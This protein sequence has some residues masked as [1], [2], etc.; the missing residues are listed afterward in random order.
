VRI[1]DRVADALRAVTRELVVVSNSPGANRWLPE[2]RVVGDVRQGR[3]SLVGLHTAVS[4]ATDAVF[5]VAWDMPFVS[6]AL[7][8]LI[9]AHAS[10]APFATIPESPRAGGLEPFCAVYTPACLPF[11]DAAL[12][13]GDLR[14]SR[15][16]AR[17]PSI[18]RV[19]LAELASA[20][21]PRT[22]FFNVNTIE[23]LANAER[24]ASRIAN[25]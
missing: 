10:G 16:L 21:D 11:V 5:V 13:A 2:A 17:L 7:T 3:G 22:L 4:L 24:I 19:T 6:P 14:L 20:G 8:R 18:T 25:R 12:D 23:D 9:T 1:I 15:A